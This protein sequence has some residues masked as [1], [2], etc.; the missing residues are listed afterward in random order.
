MKHL[1]VI[2]QNKNSTYDTYDSAIVC[3][4]SKEDAVKFHPSKGKLETD[5]DGNFIY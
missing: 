5:E 1:Y 2:S 3:A 4:D